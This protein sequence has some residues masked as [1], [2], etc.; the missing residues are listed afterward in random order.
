M[1]VGVRL[2]SRCLLSRNFRGY[3]NLHYSTKDTGNYDFRVVS[4]CFSKV[5]LKITAL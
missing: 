4:I 2:V 1:I 3:P 5:F